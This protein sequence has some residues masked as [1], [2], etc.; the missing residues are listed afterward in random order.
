LLR[1]G[2]DVVNS[3]TGPLTIVAGPGLDTINASAFDDTIRGGSGN[4]VINAGAGNDLVYGDTGND[5]INTGNGDDVIDPGPGNDVVNAGGGNDTVIIHNLCEVGQGEVLNGGGGTDTLISPV[6]LAELTQKGV[7]VLGFETIR[8]DPSSCESECV[9]KPDCSGNGICTESTPIG[10]VAC[11]CDLGWAGEDCSY[12]ALCDSDT[13]CTGPSRNQC[14]CDDRGGKWQNGSC[15]VTPQCMCEEAGNVWANGAC[16]PPGVSTSVLAPNYYV[17]SL[18]Y[19]APGHGASTY[20]GKES[21]MTTRTETTFDRRVSAVGSVTSTLTESEVKIGI[22]KK[23]GSTTETSSTHES[24]IVTISRSDGVDHTWDQFLIW[25]NPELHVTQ[26]GAGNITTV[27]TGPLG[28][29]TAIVTVH[30]L[31]TGNFNFTN[32]TKLAKLTSSDR[33]EILRTNP[34]VDF[35][36]G[37]PA[38]IRDVDMFSMPN[39]FAQMLDFQGLPRVYQIQGP[40][41]HHGSPVT[42]I[43]DVFGYSESRGSIKG[44]TGG[45]SV[46][47]LFGIEF[48]FVLKTGAMIGAEVEW[49]YENVTETVSGLQHKAE[50]LI[51]SET[52]CWH[53]NVEAWYDA[54]F[55]TYAFTPHNGDHGSQDCDSEEPATGQASTMGGVP[56]A[57]TAIELVLDDGTR[58]VVGTDPDGV[59][60]LWGYP[61]AAVAGANTTQGDALAT[62]TF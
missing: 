56:A 26:D 55:G 41:H 38:V 11:N 22:G 9:A 20:Y 58:I 16:L 29:D 25:T 53:Q 59:Y 24:G 10:G 61:S 44:N 17:L 2:N 3:S 39:R 28:A 32:R 15:C 7:V 19:A 47:L 30:E 62:T 50:V 5:V 21:S 6:P 35:S 51:G 13:C 12:L 46:Q 1:E 45:G 8:I 60:H 37:Q 23:T 33:R 42:F 34:W 52:T 14:M 49:N 31:I 48:N 4:D 57:N 27:L 18:M 40:L 54:A 36:S 43:R